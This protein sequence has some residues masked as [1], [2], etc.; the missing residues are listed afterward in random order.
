MLASPVSYTHLRAHETGRNP[1]TGEAVQVDEK[2]IPRFKTG[3]ELRLKLNSK[4]NT[5][6]SQVKGD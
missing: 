2:F 1:R 5:S 4:N 3:K 6:V